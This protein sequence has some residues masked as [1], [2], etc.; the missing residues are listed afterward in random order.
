MAIYLAK[1]AASAGQKVLLVDTDL[2][3]PQL[4][5][6]LK[7]DDAKGLSDAIESNLDVNQFIQRSSVE[8]NLCVLVAGHALSHPVRLLSSSRMRSLMHKFTAEFDLVIYMTP[9]INFSDL[10]WIG[11]QVDGVI[12]AT[13]LG[14][15]KRNVLSQAIE[16]LKIS[17]IPILGIV[18]T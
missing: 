3:A 5:A 14:K 18:T 1:A 2:R 9:P 4:H 12:I 8:E 15:I 10:S 7:L 17:Q 11:S 13:R 16:S 6:Y